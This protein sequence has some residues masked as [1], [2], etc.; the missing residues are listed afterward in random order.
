MTM[1]RIIVV[2]ILLVLTPLVALGSEIENLYKNGLNYFNANRYY[3]AE[4]QLSQLVKVLKDN[5]QT[6]QPVYY[7]AIKL[8]A[9]SQSEQGKNRD[10]S[11]LFI[12]HLEIGNKQ[13][14]INS[15]NSG[16]SLMALAES[17]YREG[18]KALALKTLLKAENLYKKLDPKY[19][20]RLEFLRAN[21]EEYLQGPF[22][23]SKLPFDL[24]YFYLACESIPLN[25][26]YSLTKAAMQE[27]IEVGVDYKPEGVWVD[28]FS[29]AK[30]TGVGSA[31]EH[32][33]RVIYIPKD[34]DVLKDE[35]CVVYTK[36]GITVSAF[37]HEG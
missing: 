15:Y 27:F 18:N 17:Y 22:N 7:Y 11:S 26:E 14:G 29:N 32:D 23:S 1:C 10:A 9:L 33:K 12:E 28:I 16:N 37:A 34:I 6:D 35:W 20:D 2:F 30:L 31:L 24:S 13:F 36:A 8:L 4:G 3:S 19:H 5:N 25:K 21:R